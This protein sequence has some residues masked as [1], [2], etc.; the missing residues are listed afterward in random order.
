M[1]ADEQFFL[2]IFSI[3]LF[4]E[5]EANA[6]HIVWVLDGFLKGQDLVRSC[7]ALDV[8]WRECACIIKLVQMMGVEVLFLGV[9]LFPLDASAPGI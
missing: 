9:G 8:L 6:T 7:G 4:F 2:A 5:A 3:L 1:V